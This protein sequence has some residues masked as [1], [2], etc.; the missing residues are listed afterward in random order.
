[1]VVTT[2]PVLPDDAVIAVRGLTVNLPRGMERPH[3]VENV[4]FDLKREYWLKQQGND[5][6]QALSCTTMT[7]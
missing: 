1:M 3:A 6:F 7:R 5:L 2:E 4:P